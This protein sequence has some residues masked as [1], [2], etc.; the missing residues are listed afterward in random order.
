MTYNCTVTA[1]R[2]VEW[3]IHRSLIRGSERFDAAERIGIDIQPRNASSQISTITLTPITY[4][5]ALEN[6]IS[7]IVVT[8]AAFEDV[9]D[10]MPAIQQYGVFIVC[11]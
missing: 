10:N 9:F 11:K 5:A 7:I 6:N 3:A 8:C 1:P 4:A 2:A